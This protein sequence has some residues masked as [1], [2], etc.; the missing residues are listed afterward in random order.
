MTCNL[1]NTI[2]TILLEPVGNA[3][4]KQGV[5]TNYKPAAC[6]GRENSQPSLMHKAVC[7]G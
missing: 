2:E 7:I 1:K 3:N 6:S 5:I 4:G